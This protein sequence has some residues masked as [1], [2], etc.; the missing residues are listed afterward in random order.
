M[1]IQSQLSPAVHCV[2]WVHLT[3]HFMYRR[4]NTAEKSVT[5]FDGDMYLKN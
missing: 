3:M 5:P 2:S 4:D 1:I